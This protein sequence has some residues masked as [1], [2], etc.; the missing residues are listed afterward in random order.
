MSPITV[1]GSG[2]ASVGSMS[3][4]PAP[5]TSS[6]SPSKISCTRGRR[7]STNLGVNAFDTSFRTRVWSG[8]SMSRIPALIR[9]QNGVCHPGGVGLPISSWDDMWR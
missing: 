8:G 7:A 2:S 9:S 1:T 3:N 5:S 4:A 6:T